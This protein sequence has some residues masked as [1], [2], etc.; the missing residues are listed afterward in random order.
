MTVVELI[1]TKKR[2]TKGGL[3]LEIIVEKLVG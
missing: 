1:K 2:M 3:K